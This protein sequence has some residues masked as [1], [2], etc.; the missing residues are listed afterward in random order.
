MKSAQR[1]KFILSSIELGMTT[2]F[3]ESTHRILKTTESLVRLAADIDIFIVRE[4]TKK[5]EQYYRGKAFEVLELLKA[6]AQLKG[7]FV[8]IISKDLV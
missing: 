5:F 7:E 4:L 2:I 1:E 6:T 8:V 3:Y